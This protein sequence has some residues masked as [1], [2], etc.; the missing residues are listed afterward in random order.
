[1]NENGACS[2]LI[3]R[4]LTTAQQSLLNSE[5]QCKQAKDMCRDKETVI[6]NLISSGKRVFFTLFLCVECNLILHIANDVQEK[7]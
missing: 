4:E 2:V 6:F 7:N 1:M 5:D 3:Q